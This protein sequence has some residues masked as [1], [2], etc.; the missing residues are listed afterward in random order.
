[1][2]IGNIYLKSH[3]LYMIIGVVVFFIAVYFIIIPTIVARHYFSQIDAKTNHLRADLKTVSSGSN[4]VIFEDPD[5][6]LTKRQELIEKTLSSVQQAQDSLNDVKQANTI[7]KLPGNGFAGQYHRALVRKERT[8]NAI[9]QSGQVLAEYSA[10]LTYINAYTEPQLY[11]ENQLTYIN[12]ILDFSSISG[13]GSNIAAIAQHL[14]AG[15]DQ[16]ATLTPPPA[17]SPLHTEALQTLSQ[18]S[19]GFEGLASGLNEDS[20]TKTYGAV[21]ALEDLALK[22]DVDD[23]QMVTSL[24]QSSPT[25]LQLSEL[26]E[27]IEHTASQP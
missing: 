22:S 26:P 5:I 19:A 15:H 14:Q 7:L 23:R 25:L 8:D 4:V 18:A 9:R 13:S 10:A 2:K 11:L 24:A 20:E 16:L 21:R 17:F 12:G 6:T 1:M 3:T 27:K